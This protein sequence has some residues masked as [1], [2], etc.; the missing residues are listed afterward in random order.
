M[1]VVEI[2]DVCNGLQVVNENH[3]LSVCENMDEVDDLISSWCEQNN[4]DP[5]EVVIGGD[6]I[7]YWTRR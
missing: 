1:V 2:Y 7:N 6:Y 3:V 4:L 5:F